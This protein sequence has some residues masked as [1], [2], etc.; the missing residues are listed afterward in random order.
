MVEGFTLVGF[1][2]QAYEVEG[3]MPLGFARGAT[4]EVPLR[5]V[6]WRIVAGLIVA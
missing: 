6:V 4:E 1:T 3:F 5:A 2:R